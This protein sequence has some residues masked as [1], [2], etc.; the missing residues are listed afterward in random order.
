MRSS[1]RRQFLGQSLGLA[2][3]LAGAKPLAQAWAQGAAPGSKMK[4]GLVTYKWGEH[5]NVPTLIQNCTESG[6]LGVELRTTHKHGVERDLTPLQ[7][8]EVKKRFENSPVTLVGIGSNENFDHVDPERLE[9]AI[10]AT[11]DFVVLSKDVGGSGVKVKPN[12]FHDGVPREQTIEQ[13]GTSLNTLGA[14]AADHGQQI[15]LEV[16]GQCSELPII[17]QIMDIAGHPSVA[18][19]WNSNDQDLK[20]EGLEHNFNLV[21]DRFGATAHIRELNV[22]D[23]PYQQ[24]MNLF[25]GMDYD[26][27][28]LLEARTKPK[29]PVAAMIEQR[30]LFEKMIAHG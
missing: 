10:Q 6:L 19:C 14:F 15:R 27:W 28:I 18:V 12:S 24:L 25:V 8:Q 5:W 2:A 26:G 4:L 21:K 13:I 1:S 29:D 17:K 11:K 22:G 3:A 30:E 23:Y 7:R 16:H 9:R 20:G